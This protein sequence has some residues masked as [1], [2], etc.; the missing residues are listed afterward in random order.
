MRFRTQ[1]ISKS[2]ADDL[3]PSIRLPFYSI[4]K[5]TAFARV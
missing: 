1:G 3:R 4:A 2:P 5:L